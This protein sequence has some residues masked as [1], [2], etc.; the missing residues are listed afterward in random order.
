MTNSTGRHARWFLRLFEFDFGVVHH[1]DVKHQAAEAL[2][3]LQTTIGEVVTL[4][5]DLPLL[6]INATSDDNSISVNN[7]S[8]E[9]TILLKAQEEQLIDFSLRR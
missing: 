4:E 2:P 5:E 7:A 9:D 6:A 1:G 8:I 3:R